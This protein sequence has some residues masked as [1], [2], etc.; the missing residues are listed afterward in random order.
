[1]YVNEAEEVKR[2]VASGC[3]GEGWKCGEA[4]EVAGVART[5]REHL[6]E[7]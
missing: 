6:I 4:V 1:M 3:A 2:R 7:Q 5:G